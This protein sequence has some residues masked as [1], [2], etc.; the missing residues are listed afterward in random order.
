MDGQRVPDLE[1]MDEQ[2]VERFLTELASALSPEEEYR[3]PHPEDYV[4]EMPQSGERFRGQ[5]NMRAF[6][7]AFPDHS[8]RPSI[9]AGCWSGTGGGP[10]RASST[11]ARGG[12]PTA[13]PSSN[14][15]TARY[16]GTGAISL[17][18]SRRRG[19]ARIWS[20]GWRPRF[21]TQPNFL[22]LRKAEVQLRRKPLLGTSVNKSKKKQCIWGMRRAPDAA[23]NMRGGNTERGQSLK[24][25]PSPEGRR[26]RCAP[27]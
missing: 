20:S 22:K 26:N 17:S 7:E 5:E 4:M 8:T 18:P 3:I 19:G 14:S 27:R 16:G 25:S 6:Q 9:R 11:T 10:S 21:R 1:E 12:S 24:R 13:W 15:K 2:Q 23:I